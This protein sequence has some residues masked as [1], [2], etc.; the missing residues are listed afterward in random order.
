MAQQK[1]YSTQEFSA[2]TGMA[3]S[4]IT[5]LLRAGKLQGEKISGK[6]MIPESQLPSDISPLEAK[7][8]ESVSEKRFFSVEEFTDMTYLT[9]FGVEQW[10]KKGLLIG[11]LKDD[12][13]WRVDAECLNIPNV[14]R[15]I[16]E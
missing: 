3:V 15:L 16:R 7:A 10:L 13:S 12:G 1:L 2:L 5:K 8:E 11:Q 6:W 14:K 9:A 4:K